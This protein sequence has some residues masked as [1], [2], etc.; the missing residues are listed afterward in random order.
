MDL[1]S[2][3]AVSAE[4]DVQLV[5]L[6]LKAQK[7]EE[8]ENNPTELELALKTAKE[9]AIVSI[10]KEKSNVGHLAIAEFKKS[11]EFVGF[12][13]ERYDGGWVA[14]KRCVCHTHPSFE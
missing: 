4:T 8:A 14:A 7:L 12:L 13:G 9:E 1:T 2:E 3:K 10:E 11:R 6:R 5:G